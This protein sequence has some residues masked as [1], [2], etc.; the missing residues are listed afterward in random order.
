MPITIT[1]AE[2]I[3]IIDQRVAQALASGN[4]TATGVVTSVNTAALSAQVTFDPSGVSAPVGV[5]GH[6]LAAE[7]DRV[8]MHRYGGN[9]VRAERSTDERLGE[10]V[11]DWFVTGVTNTR[12]ILGSTSINQA[13]GSGQVTSNSWT[14]MPGSPTMTL[15][16][17]LDSTAVV[18]GM[19]WSGYGD[20]IG[21]TVEWGLTK[22]G[23]ST[24]DKF[25]DFQVA[26]T[27]GAA[28]SDRQP[29]LSGFRRFTGWAAGTYPLVF[30]WKLPAGVYFEQDGGDWLSGI[31][32]EV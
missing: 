22:D 29:G 3:A 16:K 23:G 12:P 26:N 14:N 32:W 9:K 24:T 21:T 5:L 2:L 27:T 15:V 28:F 10:R 25:G 19:Y 31:A 30:R 7:G 4:D 1:E 6:V 17:S 8:V 13:T 11:G 20:N 18:A